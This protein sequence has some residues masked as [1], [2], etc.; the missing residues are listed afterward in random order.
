MLENC[1]VWKDIKGYEGRYQVSNYGRVW[2]IISQ[3]YLKFRYDK[4]GYLLVTLYA[5]NGK[6][7]TEKVHRLVALTFISNPFGFPQVN[8]KD[9]DKTNNFISNLEWVS[10]KYNVNYGTRNDR[11][12]KAMMKPVYCVELKKFYKSQTEAAQELNLKQANISAV[13]RGKAKTTGGY[14]FCFVGGDVI[15]DD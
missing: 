4:D 9:E 5:K 12:S 8:H 6:A 10:P 14:H 13:C 3:R 15:A 1:E 7:I 2:S 11:A